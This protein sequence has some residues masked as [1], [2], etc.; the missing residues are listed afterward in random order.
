MTPEIMGILNVTPDSFSD[1]GLFLLEE[2]ALA[3]ALEMVACGASVIDVGGEST[4]PGAA[5]V[6]VEQELSRVIPVIRELHSASPDTTIS[7]DTTK[8]R[9]ADEA[10]RA[11]ATLIND[12]SAGRVDP[13]ILDVASASGARFALMHMQ[14]TPRTMQLDPHYD[15]V[16]SEVRRHLEERVEVAEKAGIALGKILVDPGIGFGKTLKHNLLLLR[17]LSEIRVPGTQ[18]LLGTSRKS[19]IAKISDDAEQRL[20]GSLATLGYTLPQQVDMVRVHDVR[21]TAQFFRVWAAIA[22]A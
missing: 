22:D 19:F 3:H 16:V 11:G 20:A 5:P 7:I 18:L 8:S 10:L 17:N 21:E 15:D 13:E 2:H 14:G 6:S 1:G 12:I 4:R 9:V